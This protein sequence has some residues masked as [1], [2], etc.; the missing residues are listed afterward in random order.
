VQLTSLSTKYSNMSEV[1][2]IFFGAIDEAGRCDAW[3]LKMAGHNN[4]FFFRMHIRAARLN[5]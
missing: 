2:T 5:V 3:T 4:G 1:W